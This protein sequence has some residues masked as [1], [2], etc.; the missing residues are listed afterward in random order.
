MSPMPGRQT[1][2][3]PSPST[4]YARR[5]SGRFNHCV[6]LM[7]GT[8]WLVALAQKLIALA[9]RVK[10]RLWDV[11]DGARHVLRRPGPRTDVARRR[12]DQAPG[13]LLLEDVR[14]PPRRTGAGEH[15]REHVGRD[16]RE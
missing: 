4:S 6:A 14:R 8:P 5:P 13:S 9:K 10:R 16:L 12:T 15:R 1:T 2:S 7:T 11:S 3:G